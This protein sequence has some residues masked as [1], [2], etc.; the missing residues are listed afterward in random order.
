MP[1]LEALWR[2]K[3]KDGLRVIGL[4]LGESPATVKAYVRS[5]KITFPIVIDRGMKVA[6]TYGVRFT[7]T[8]ILIDG[9]GVVRAGGS[10]AKEWTSPAA[11][12]AV[13]VLFETQRVSAARPAGP[14]LPG[15]GVREGGKP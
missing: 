12:A 6:T 14:S 2:A 15:R 7:P 10:G 5:T 13:G 4:N 9:A 11:H 1:S 8:H 3:R